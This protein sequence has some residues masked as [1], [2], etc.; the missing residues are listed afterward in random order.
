M[1]MVEMLNKALTPTVA[2]D[3]TPIDIKLDGL[4]YVLW[5]QVVEM[6]IFE[7]NKLGYINGDLPQPA[8]TDPSFWRWRTE[9]VIVKG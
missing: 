1:K 7:R 8:S 5:S 9:N 2:A 4:N 6:F 3:T